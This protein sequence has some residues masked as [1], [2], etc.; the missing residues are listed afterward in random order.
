MNATRQ[1]YQLQGVELDIESKKLALARDQAR[2]GKS[3]AV[4][5]L[6]AK[7]DA[8]KQR[9]DELGSQQHSAE[10]EIEGIETKLTAANEAMYSG[11]VSSPKELSNLQHE[12]KG[13][14]A[15]RG[16]LE[17]KALDIMEQTEL[18]T[19]NLARSKGELKALEGRWRAEQRELAVLIEKLK[20]TLTDLEHKRQLMLAAIPSPA[21]DL[22]RQLREQ[23]GRAVARVDQGTCGG[24]RISLSTSELQWARG[25]R[26][27]ECSSCGRILFL[28]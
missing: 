25:D 5:E 14:N 13:L 28:D 23:K 24:C 1:L 20:E 4:A 22:Y 15:R 27:V 6:K 21:A 8:V 10:W 7:I 12:V 11:R 9:L 19:A 17:E 16:Q 3:R 2:L 18:V 26:L